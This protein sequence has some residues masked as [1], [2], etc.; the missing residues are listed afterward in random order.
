MEKVRARASRLLP[1]ESLEE[2]KDTAIEPLVYPL[3]GRLLT[4]ERQ[5]E[6]QQLQQ[7]LSQTQAII[8]RVQ[9]QGAAEESAKAGVIAQ[10]YAIGL[11]LLAE[12]E[13]EIR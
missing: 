12:I 1:G 13:K 6:R 8:E 9:R 4:A 2:N 5:D 3:L 11:S 7:M 10:A